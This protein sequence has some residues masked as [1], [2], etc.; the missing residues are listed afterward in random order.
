MRSARTASIV[1]A[2][3]D[4][5][6][7]VSE[8]TRAADGTVTATVTELEGLSVQEARAIVTITRLLAGTTVVTTRARPV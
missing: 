1:T 7:T 6:S 2:G 8:A 4:L 5:I 3:T